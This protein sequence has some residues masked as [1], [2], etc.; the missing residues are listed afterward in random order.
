VVRVF[1]GITILVAV[2]VGADLLLRGMTGVSLPEIA[3]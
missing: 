3:K 2:I 1:A